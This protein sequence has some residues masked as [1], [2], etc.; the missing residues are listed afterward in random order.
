[1]AKIKTTVER[2]LLSMLVLAGI[3]SRVSLFAQL[4]PVS[5][6][7]ILP[8]VQRCVQCHGDA[9][10]MGSLDLRSRASILQG[11]N[12]GPAISPGHADDSLLIKRV[13]GV[14]KPK[15]PM[16]QVTPLT[17]EE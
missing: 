9:P 1:M 7:D 10:Q 8:I 6:K 17:A 4:T 5:D 16:A 3:G 13:T 15:M 11:G 2:L 12:S 14:V